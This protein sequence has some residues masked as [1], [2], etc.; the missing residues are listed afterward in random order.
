[1]VVLKR[2]GTEGLLNLEH[3]ISKAD[4]GIETVNADQVHFARHAFYEYGKSRHPVLLNF[5]VKTQDSLE[6]TL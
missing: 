4:I 1:M 2:F 6:I 3:F 5:E